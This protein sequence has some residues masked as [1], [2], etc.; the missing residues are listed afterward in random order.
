MDAFSSMLQS[1]GGSGGTGAGLGSLLNLGGSLFGLINQMS[2]ASKEKSAMDQSIYY[3]KN[4]GAI[5]ALVNQYEQPLSKGLTSGVSNVVNAQLAEQGLSQA[6]GIQSEVLAQALAP[7][8]QNEQQMAITE[9]FKALGLPLQALQAIQSTMRPGQ[10][11]Q[12]FKGIMP[13]QPQASGGQDSSGL[14]YT[15][16]FWDDPST[17]TPPP[18]DNSF[19]MVPWISPQGDGGGS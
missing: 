11:A 15:P 16:G 7:Y 4:P 12:L 13:Q 8:Q 2:L 9:A 10:L 17:F 1:F 5:N 6:P 18:T 3:S 14:S 19:S